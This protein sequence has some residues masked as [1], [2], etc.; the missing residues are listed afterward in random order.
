MIMTK[1][2]KYNEDKICDEI[3]GYIKE[4]YGKHYSIGADGFQVQDLLKTLK[5]SKNFCQANAIK[6][7]CRYGKKLGRNRNY[8]LKA[9]HYV[10]LLINQD[11]EDGLENELKNVGVAEGISDTVTDL[12]DIAKHVD[13][14]PDMFKESVRASVL[15]NVSVGVNVAIS[16]LF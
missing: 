14:N 11:D 7:L 6:Y 5:I 12:G 8:L 10:I 1:P 4:T 15:T 2:F 3:K 16:Y 9:I 13:D